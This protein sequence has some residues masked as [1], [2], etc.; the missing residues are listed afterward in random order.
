MFER[1]L[2]Q[3]EKTLAAERGRSP[4]DAAS[5]FGDA[6]GPT[7]AAAVDHPRA[8][9][10]VAEAGPPI[11]APAVPRQPISEAPSGG[12]PAE[13]PLADEGPFPEEPFEEARRPRLVGG[14]KSKGRRLVKPEAPAQATM[15]PEQRLLIL[16]TWQRSGL[17]AGDF[18]A[19]VGLSKHTLYGWK[20]KFD[21]LGPGGLMDQTRGGPKG[22]RVHELTKRTILM[23]KQANPEWGCQ[24]ISD[25]LLRGPALPASAA[26]VSRVLHEAGYQLEEAATHPH[27]DKQRRFERATPN[28]LWQTDLF[29]FVLK[30]QNRRVYMVAFMDD[31]SRFI[32]G[33]GIH[34]SQASAL[35]L[36]VVRAAIVAHGTP[37]EMLTD[38][39][40]QYVTWRGTSVFHREMDKRGIKHIVAKPQRPQTLGKV[41]RFWGTLWRECLDTSVFV[42]LEDAR[43]R[44]GHFIDY[45]N[46]Q[47]PHQ[48][49]EGLVPADRFF[50]AASE[51]LT[52]LR[53]RVAAN[54]LELARNGVPKAP[55]YV[56]GRIG[57]RAFSV[58]AEGERMILK[59][60]GQ[61]RTEVDLG[62]AEAAELP[63]IDSAAARLP[64]EMPLPVCP[65]GSPS[66]ATGY[67]D[68]VEGEV[69]PGGSPLDAG[70][71]RLDAASRAERPTDAELGQG[72]TS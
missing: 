66:A 58:H 40:S 29:T 14:G 5:V 46:F 33:Y 6:V 38:N 69:G 44:V 41:E 55:F 51:V 11:T 24:R 22:S 68:V 27:P 50:G 49:I 34:A 13:D 57:E 25:M 2:E 39:G 72:G 71:R 47:R 9:P 26:A 10:P 52:T 28:Q 53:L 54:A 43:R 3:D 4:S 64:A 35:V 23:L 15:T 31:H 59:R 21:Q 62:A 60:E 8:V 16:D 65:D 45:Y 63:L 20:K 36:E 37:Q 19:L 30:R 7:P 1:E 42:D 12:S 32:T 18:A 61:E 56:T 17:P 70:L 48:G 67:A